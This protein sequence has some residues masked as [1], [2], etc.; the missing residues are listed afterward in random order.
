MIF[1]HT[2][3]LQLI[4][5]II[6]KKKIPHAILFSGPNNIGKREISLTIIKYLSSNH[7]EDFFSF[8]QKNCN[9][10]TCNLIN[11]GNFPDLIELENSNGQISITQIRDARSK[12]LVAPNYSFNFVIIN[13]AENLSQEAA[14]AL[15]KILEEPRKSTIFFLLTSFPN[16]LPKTILSRVSTFKFNPLSKNEIKNFLEKLD[17]QI[18]AKNKGK[19][20]DFSLGRPGIAK[21]LS[22]DKKKLLYYNSLLEEIE[23]LYKLSIFEKIKLC[24]TIEKT[25]KIEDFLFLIDFWFKDLLFAKKNIE[26]ISFSFKK[27]EIWQAS[28]FFSSEKL[29]EILKSIFKIKKYIFFSNVSRLLALENLLLE[30]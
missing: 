7:D 17:N 5:K 23:K 24:E 2:K 12:L 15:L 29:E 18:D 16:T 4:S 11:T 9:C 19:I 20:I 30:I 27:D 6:E 21:K 10:K 26:N 14:G 13:N 28:K 8:S 3:N 1:G 22:I 25:G